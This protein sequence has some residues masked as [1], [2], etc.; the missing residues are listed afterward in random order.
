MPPAFLFILLL[1][2]LHPGLATAQ[3]SLADCILTHPKS[4]AVVRAS[5]VVLE[6]P[7]DHDQAD[8]GT[9]SLH[10]AVIPAKNSH[11]S[12]DPLFFFAGGPGQSAMRSAA[13]LTRF[14]NEAG[15]DRDLVFIDQRGTGRST[16]LDC[17]LDD[18]LQN[19]ISDDKKIVQKTRE[20]LESLTA[21]PSYFTSYQA[22][23]DVDLVRQALDYEKIN[24]LGVSYGTRMV[25]LYLKAYPQS[26][27]SVILDG[28]VP[29]DIVLGPEFSKNLHAS[30]DLLIE[31]CV[32]DEVCSEAFPDLKNDWQTY[33]KIPS[34]EQRQLTL[35]HPRTGERL[36]LD[37]DREVM[38]SALRLLSY[39][40]ITQ[41]MIPLLLHNS[42][43]GDWQPL[44][45]QAIQVAAALE[46]ELSMG[47]HNSVIC[48]EEAPFLTAKT[49]DTEKLLGRMQQQ[50]KT[51][52][53]QW[54]TGRV[55][56]HQHAVTAFSVPALLLS[57]ELDPVTPPGYADQAAA[58]FTD[59]RHITV[60]GQ[61][62]NVIEKGCIPKLAKQFLDELVLTDEQVACVDRTPRLP[63]FIDL[64]GPA[65]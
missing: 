55:F 56:E 54:P 43:K 26:V 13:I 57:G 35:T 6:V 45:S 11:A 15:K 61:G 10:L 23:H 38:D 7:L 25:Q 41:T 52:C 27:R 63:F 22:V 9:L 30:L 53:E 50:L 21:D 24:L 20:C 34:R 64:M 28:V 16:P 17:P 44:I 8:A 18:D 3:V 42:A 31:H 14:R 39:S 12:A 37:V 5:C 33:L 59:R 29:V 19:L 58:H 32:A 60:K 65:S 46:T 48:S 2:A 62:H 36:A 1:I 49:Q 40:N 4:P 47:M 51:I